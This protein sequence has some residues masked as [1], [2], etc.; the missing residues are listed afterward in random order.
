VVFTDHDTV[1]CINTMQNKSNILTRWG[2]ML[3]GYNL[4]IKHIKC[5][6]SFIANVLSRVMDEMH[7]I[8]AS[9]ITI[10]QV[11]FFQLWIIFSDLSQ[12]FK[13]N[14]PFGRSMSFLPS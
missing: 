3:Q 10:R 13:N 9:K 4:I 2:L 7:T 5:N 14:L 6:D 12:S 11:I 8:I 1:I